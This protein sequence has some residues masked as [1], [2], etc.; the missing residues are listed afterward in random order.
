[1]KTT[2][3]FIRTALFV[4]LM[5]VGAMINVTIIPDIPFTL[6]TMFALMAG[7]VLGKKFGT[8]SQIVYLAL[9]LIGL[10]V[11]AQFQGGFGAVLRPTFGFLLGFILGAFL[12]ALL[13]EK[14]PI[15]NN[16]LKAFLSA[17]VGMIA[18]YALGISYFY[19]LINYFIGKDMSFFAI[20]IM[21][22][23]FMIPDG[24]KLT[25]AAFMGVILRKRMQDHH[26][27]D[28]EKE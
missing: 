28:M 7:L 2:K 19:F 20:I 17:L 25:A 8:L 11:F 22:I 5:I 1:M 24:I 14:L 9:G 15:K 6:Q 27:M 18:I 26:L 23:P 21:M 12:C 10:P 4:A 16:Y 3:P 13:Y